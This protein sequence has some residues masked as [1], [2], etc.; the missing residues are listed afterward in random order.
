M[1]TGEPYEPLPGAKNAWMEKPNKYH[2]IQLL[3]AFLAGL[4]CL[5]PGMSMGFSAVALPELRPRTVGPYPVHS[6]NANDTAHLN[7]TEALIVLEAASNTNGNLTLTDEESAWFMSIAMATT[8]LGC[9][10]S[11]YLIDAIGRKGALLSV[12]FPGIVG[13]LMLATV[14]KFVPPAPA[15]FASTAVFAQMILGRALNGIAIGMSSSPGSVLVSETSSPRFRG[16]V[17]S[18]SSFFV[19]LGVLLAYFMGDV[20]SGW[21]MIAAFGAIITGLIAFLST[22]LPESPVWLRSK[23]LYGDADWVCY[24]L[25]LKTRGAVTEGAF[26]KEDNGTSLQETSDGVGVMDSVRRLLEPKTRRPMLILAGLFLLQQAS[27]L[28][29]VTF[30][31]VEIAAASGIR[32]AIVNSNMTAVLIGTCNLVGLSLVITFIDKL[33]RR[34]AAICSATGMAIAMA[35]LGLYVQIIQPQYSHPGKHRPL[36]TKLSNYSRYSA[37]GNYSNYYSSH[38]NSSG[39]PEDLAIPES[40]WHSWIPLVALLSW[41]F[42]AALGLSPLPWTLPPELLPAKTRGIGFGILSASAYSFAFVALRVFSDLVAP[43]GLAGC[44]YIMSSAAAA[45][46]VY[47]AVLVPETKGMAI[48]GL[49]E[50]GGRWKEVHA[51]VNSTPAPVAAPAVPAERYGDVL[52]YG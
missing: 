26:G 23:G 40:P 50:R 11:G 13:W 19:A 42:S 17:I 43:L 48:D 35:V 37:A 1:A 15:G 12:A 47:V 38:F 2:L 14:P 32:G 46:A 25:G 7:G 4:S 34:P 21:R 51:S 16:A 6:A 29:V 45:A 8:P 24:R 30:N 44:M 52:V 9:F 18:M 31:A 5:A 28:Y 27:G 22:M 39:L 33:G 10:I 41:S 3:M 49:E 20:A 36:W